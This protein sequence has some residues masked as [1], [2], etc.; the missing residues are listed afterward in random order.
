MEQCIAFT[1]TID[2]PDSVRPFSIIGFIL[3]LMVGK[4]I[5]ARSN[6][7]LVERI[8][9]LIHH[10]GLQVATIEDARAILGIVK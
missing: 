1:S 6:V 7:E 10:M 9:A 2:Q 5:S 4:L 8:V 3:S